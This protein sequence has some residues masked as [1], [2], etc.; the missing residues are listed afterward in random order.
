MFLFALLKAALIFASTC[1]ILGN[2]FYALGLPCNSLILVMIGRLLNGFGSARSINRRYIADTCTPRE[3]TAAS[4]NF[5][6][7]GA[8]GMAAGPAIASLLHIGSPDNDF[9]EG[10]IHEH[11]EETIIEDNADP[12]VIVTDDDKVLFNNT[13]V[14]WTPENAPGWFMLVI[15]SVYLVMLWLHFEDPQKHVKPPKNLSTDVELAKGTGEKQALLTPDKQDSN[16]DDEEEDKETEIPL[17]RNIP[18]MITFLVYFV[19][20]LVLECLLSSTSTLTSYYFDWDSSVNGV[21]LA[22]LGLLMLPANLG[23][24]FLARNYDD[25]ELIVACQIAMLVGCCG[26]I[27]YTASK[28]RYTII[29]YVLFSVIVFLS[30]NALEGPN[31]SLLSKTI[32]PSWS[33][34][35]FNVGLLATEAGT[36]G[37]AVGDLLLS[38]WGFGGIG[39]LLNTT[40]RSMAIYS[41][42]SLALSTYFFDHLEPYEKDL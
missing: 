36:L 35:I 17:W 23:V 5:V 25:R 24:A 33:Q 1:S 29:Q 7:A 13:R 16:S 38:V 34:G 28:D 27:Q 18:V 37:R 21:Y 32:P 9:R 8:L 41:F 14:W 10:T 40:F 22:V 31:M 30:T 11:T 12:F 20:K 26:M 42:V 39:S 2:I 6:T 19:L 3:R 4:A 15:W